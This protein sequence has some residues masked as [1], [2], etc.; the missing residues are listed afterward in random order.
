MFANAAMFR[1]AA[2]NALRSRH[3]I[4]RSL[5]NKTTGILWRQQQ[6]HSVQ[7]R[8]PTNV[9]GQLAFAKRG[10]ADTPQGTG[11]EGKTPD[12][13]KNV[14]EGVRD[15]SATGYGTPPGIP[16][17][18]QLP[19]TP[20]SQNADPIL[21]TDAT[22]T[23]FSQQ[24]S[25]AAREA[26]QPTD[27]LNP[28]PPPPPPP[29]DDPHS[30]VLPGHGRGA[31]GLPK[32]AY[33]SSADRKRERVARWSFFLFFVTLAAGALY[34]GRNWEKEEEIKAHS[35]D[36]PN[37][38]SA[39]LW[40]ARLRARVRA[41]LNYYE[42]P[43]F[44]KLLP[45]PIPEYQPPYTLVLA[46]EDLLVHT[47]WDKNH[48]WR[49]AKRPGLDYFLGYLSMYYELVVFS[50]SPSHLVVPIVEKLNSYPG[51]IS[52]FLAREATRYK[53]GKYIKDLAHLNRDLSKVI[54]I[55]TKK[56][57]AEMQPDNS[58][59]IP[60]WT[61][62]PK[63]RE[64]LA[65]I[66]VLEFIAAMGVSDVRPVI[67][68]FGDKHIPTEFALREAAARKRFN[69]RLA[70]EKAKRKLDAKGGW[71]SQ[72][73]GIKSAPEKEKE[74]EKMLQDLIREKGQE[75]YKHM[76]KVLEEQRPK[77]EEEERQRIKEMAEATKTSLSKVLT[78][79]K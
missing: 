3:Y 10:Y 30:R 33:I 47:E 38:M 72:L 65:L 51:F 61:G 62:D 48:G 55:D 5:S 59:I 70:E 20:S 1:S 75:N 4:A 18:P 15:S 53:D 37:G 26:E 13:A 40:Y 36:A 39:K 41:I 64:L 79:A 34:L 31:D 60:P 8:L 16:T 44:E 27:S 21:P 67:R 25:A 71:M 19:S 63:D 6:L 11:P 66:N 74:Q 17:G 22:A 58:I 14:P 32:S 76:M 9:L 69:E 2:V 54:M 46:L 12:S 28:P 68:D 45:D 77:H 42:E 52:Q 29:G 56:E 57:A 7:S 78:G 35:E 43:V 73:L 24:E 23:P 49:S 50:D